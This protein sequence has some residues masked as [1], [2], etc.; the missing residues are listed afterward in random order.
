MD[1]HLISIRWFVKNLSPCYSTPQSHTVVLLPSPSGP[2]SPSLVKS[3]ISYPQS[4]NVQVSNSPSNL[5]KCLIPPQ[6]SYPS[7]REKRSIPHTV[8]WLPVNLRGTN[9]PTVEITDTRTPSSHKEQRGYVKFWRTY[10]EQ[11]PLLWFEII[12]HP[13]ALRALRKE[14][15]CSRKSGD[16]ESSQF[17]LHAT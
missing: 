11:R 15:E 9:W 17:E 2:A 5:Q 7:W 6:W 8:Q 16:S 10:S 13:H 14:V 1:S 4:W 3:P 12:G